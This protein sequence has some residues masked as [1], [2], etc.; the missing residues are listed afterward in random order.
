[1]TDRSNAVVVRWTPLCGE[2]R[3]YVFEPR[4]DGDYL[5]IEH[6]WNGCQWRQ[7]GAEI[8]ET[9]TVEIGPGATDVVERATE[10]SGETVTGP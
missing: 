5:Q 4:D 1:M 6:E 8:V 9:V 10:A 3:R 2:P 7:V